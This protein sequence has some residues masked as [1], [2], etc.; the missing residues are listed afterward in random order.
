MAQNRL[1][2]IS[3]T[4]SGSL[5]KHLLKSYYEGGTQ[6]TSIIKF[7]MPSNSQKNPV[8]QMGIILHYW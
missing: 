8:R 2:C 6:D 1:N 7:L 5:T 3:V 4:F